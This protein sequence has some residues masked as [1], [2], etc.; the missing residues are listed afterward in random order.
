MVKMCFSFLVFFIITIACD[1]VSKENSE[2]VVYDFTT[3]IPA[4]GNSWIKNNPGKTEALVLDTGIHNWTSTD[5]VVQIYFATSEAG[6]LQ[7]GIKSKVPE[8]T[9]ELKVILDGDSREI[10]LSNLEYQD[11]TIGNFENVTPGYHTLEL[12]ATQKS[13][14][15]VA[16]VT[17]VLLGGSIAESQI[18]FIKEP[19][20]FYFGRRGPSDH[21]NFTIPEDK[22]LL[23]FYSEI[24][25]PEAEDKIGSYFMADG[26]NYGYFGIQVNS[27]TE[28]RVIFSVWSPYTTDDPSEIPEDERIILLDKGANVYASEFGNEGSGGHSH[29]KYNWSAETT[30]KFLLK[31]EP[32]ENNSTDYTAYFYA[33]E[34][35][36]QLIASFRRPKTASYLKGFYSFLENFSP[37]TGNK[38]RKALYKNQWV[39]DTSGS[40]T[41]IT[42]A[43]FTVDSTARAGR[44]LDYSGGVEQN[45][46][47]LRNCGFF[48]DNTEPDIFFN[49]TSLNT[50][51]QIDFDDLD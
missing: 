12:I 50:S 41:E 23:Y 9:T 7:L 46:F 39:Y 37:L 35:E 18:T 22:D 51:P 29:L 28:R 15:Y 45:S 10:S 20:N 43:K 21:L 27:E 14:A 6:N 25:V 1:T 30:Y 26:F 33:P 44:R 17:E 5:D 48:S 11:I 4:G 24:E 49:R 34:L 36:W 8:G 13:G 32:S 2:N 42:E 16:D 38:E 19:E 31:G 47:Y 3:R 40:W